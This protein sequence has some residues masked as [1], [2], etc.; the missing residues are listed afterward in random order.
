MHCAALLVALQS[1][2]LP[3]VMTPECDSLFPKKQDS[4]EKEKTGRTSVYAYQE[5]MYLNNSF[6]FYTS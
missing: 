2:Y 1:T 5:K 6:P 3:S 4:C